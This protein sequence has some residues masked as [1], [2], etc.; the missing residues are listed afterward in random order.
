[1]MDIFLVIFSNI[2]ENLLQ[3][4]PLDGCFLKVFVSR[5]QSPETLKKTALKNLRNFWR[6]SSLAYIYFSEE[7]Q[8]TSD[9]FLR[10]LWNVLEQLFQRTLPDG[11]F[12]EYLGEGC[13]SLN[14]NEGC[15]SSTL[16]GRDSV[17]KVYSC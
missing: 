2:L 6:N 11:C 1:M 17:N 5:K 13:R 9:G 4:T 8:S 14:K 3:G 16:T 12:W 7:N 15:S 10:I